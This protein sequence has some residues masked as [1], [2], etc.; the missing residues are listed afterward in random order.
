MPQ[1]LDNVNYKYASVA[2][3]KQRQLATLVQASRKQSALDRILD[4]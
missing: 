4:V 1:S 3:Y 2:N